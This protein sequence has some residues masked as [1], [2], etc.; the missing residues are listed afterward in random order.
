MLSCE[1]VHRNRSELE[2]WH[3]I[4][5]SIRIDQCM[6]HH[7]SSSDL[8]R[9]GAML[10]RSQVRNVSMDDGE[11]NRAGKWLPRL[12]TA[13]IKR[14]QTKKSINE[15]SVSFFPN[16]STS[17][18][19]SCSFQLHSPSKSFDSLP[20]NFQHSRLSSKF[21]AS[22]RK[23]ESS[24]QLSQEL[25][26]AAELTIKTETLY[27]KTHSRVILK[28]GKLAQ[29]TEVLSQIQPKND[30]LMETEGL[31]KQLNAELG[32]VMGR[33]KREKNDRETMENMII[34][35]KSGLAGRVKRINSLRDKIEVVNSDIE[36]VKIDTE[37]VK[38]QQKMLILDYENTQKEFELQ[39]HFRLLQ[40]SK[41]KNDYKTKQKLLFFLQN[42][43]QI[44]ADSK[45]TEI[46]EK[47]ALL[48][49]KAAIIQENENISNQIS[50]IEAE[51]QKMDLQVFTIKEKID[52]SSLF[53]ILPYW[54]YLTITRNSLETY[55][56]NTQKYIQELTVKRK[57]AKRQLNYL[58]F[59][60]D[61]NQSLLSLSYLKSAQSTLQAKLTELTNSENCMQQVCDLIIDAMNVVNLIAL[62]VFPKGRVADFT[63]ATVQKCLKLCGDELS[64]LVDR[65]EKPT[66]RVSKHST[67]PSE[68]SSN[69]VSIFNPRPDYLP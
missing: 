46:T 33:V 23:L 54:Q 50:T 41:A 40:L 57:K 20:I 26:L 48:E 12:S 63:P 18:R 58:L 31:M 5:F 69:P 32:E 7:T 53:D 9:Q 13:A 8:T 61:G 30:C 1:G 64:S 67:N 6:K 56:E 19:V 68:S 59:E 21:P 43:H 11:S 16:A 66:E 25:T 36:T 42:H 62:S 10:D 55:I 44:S 52:I 4:I 35:R 29:L 22:L 38:K 24:Q 45:Q 14:S 15:L 37:L 27:D 2:A 17:T 49:R 51:S 3:A 39:T 65:S 47:I 60:F 34:T 28:R